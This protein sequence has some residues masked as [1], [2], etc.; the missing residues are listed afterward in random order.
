[1]SYSGQY[2]RIQRKAGGL[3]A[4]DRQ[5]IRAARTKLKKSGLTRDKRQ[6]RQA[7]IKALLDI[8]HNQQKKGF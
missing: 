1:M 4:S 2:L 8:H 3:A 7:W 6:S 5:L